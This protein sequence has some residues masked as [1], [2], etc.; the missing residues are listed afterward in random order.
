M[1][2]HTGAPGECCPRELRTADMR[3]A[4][5]LHMVPSAQRRH[6]GPGSP[7][8]QSPARSF[9][10]APTPPRRESIV[11]AT[12]L[13]DTADRGYGGTRVSD[14][15][16]STRTVLV[17]GAFGNVGT[18]VVASLIAGGHNVVTLD[19]GNA[20]NR[21]RAR[22]LRRYK[23]D[24]VWADVADRVALAHA[25]AA[26]DTVVHLAALIP[27][28]SDRVP[29][30]AARVNVEGTRAVVDSIGAAAGA[31][32]L[33][34][35][36][37]LSV[38]GRTQH[39]APPRKVGE[40]V[41]PCDHYGRTKRDAETIVRSADI[42][43]VILRLGAVLPLQLPLVI[44]PIMFE[45]PL[46]DRIE[47]VHTLDVGD[48]FVA[49]ATRVDVSRQ[50]LNVGGGQLCQL[51]Q[52][53]LIGRPLEALGVGMLP[54]AAFASQSFHTDWLDSDDAQ[55]LFSYQA[56]GFDDYVADVGQRYRWRRPAIRLLSP[57]IRRTMLRS[58][59]YWRAAQRH[60]RR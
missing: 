41:N 34:H 50:V 36:S 23:V 35:A 37:S 44:D 28:L 51:H 12:A 38:Y 18:S 13:L 49:A 1:I 58:S 53:E 32:R 40:P 24:H 20:G 11:R 56:R 4:G 42:D 31:I 59:P 8:A 26:V 14:A 10:T 48:A 43:W 39:L 15:N 46:T 9:A 7:L 6:N 25:L 52:R 21:R 33:V 60:G 54:E 45:V 29:A 5:T 2:A 3:L 30:E 47:F 19:L 17:T 22:R 55:R 16:Q 57:L 27:P